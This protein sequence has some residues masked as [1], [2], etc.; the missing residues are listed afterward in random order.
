MILLLAESGFLIGFPHSVYV[1]YISIYI[2][3]YIYTH[4]H[5]VLNLLTNKMCYMENSGL[6]K[7]QNVISQLLFGL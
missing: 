1:L 6:R 7:I 3:V 2:S 4:T 5:N